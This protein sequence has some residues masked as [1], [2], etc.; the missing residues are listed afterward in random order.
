MA[1]NTKFDADSL[2]G[3]L[4]GV[5]ETKTQ[6]VAKSK[7]VTEKKPAKKAPVSSGKATSYKK[8]AASSAVKKP[9]KKEPVI[10]VEI[11]DKPKKTVREEL[12]GTRG[13]KGMKLP[14]V[15]ISC[16]EEVFDYIC[17]ESRRR[18]ISRNVFVN[19]II[20]GYKNSPEG[21]SKID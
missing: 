21:I 2:F 15:H 8:A 7:P 13:H 14:Y 10:S 12:E 20:L 17:L 16:T 18:G 11:E 4:Q 5:S 1:R 9:E 6:E 3:D 19:E